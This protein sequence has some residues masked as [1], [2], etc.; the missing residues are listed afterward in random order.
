MEHV[1]PPTRCVPQLLVCEKS[2][3]VV[4]L[5]IG[6]GVVNTL[7]SVTE[8]VAFV[9]SSTVFEKFTLSGLAL[10]PVPVPVRLITCGLLGS[11]SVTVTVPL[12]E[13]VVVGVNRMLSEQL[14]PTFSTFAVQPVTEKLPVATM[15]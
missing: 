3:F 15:L 5:A 10:S 2:P 6:S 11:L 4:M 8:R 12:G 14:A 9:P 1:P 13:P 7:V